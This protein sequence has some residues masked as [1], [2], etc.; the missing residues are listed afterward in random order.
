MTVDGDQT[1]GN[2]ATVMAEENLA[3]AIEAESPP[4]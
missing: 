3:S 2:L 4:Y 1:A